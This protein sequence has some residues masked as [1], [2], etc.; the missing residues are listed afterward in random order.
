LA[1]HGPDGTVV[2]D[3]GPEIERNGRTI[4]ARLDRSTTLPEAIWVG[5]FDAHG[6]RSEGET[7]DDV[8]ALA[9]ENAD[10]ANR[11]LEAGPLA[12]RAVFINDATI[13]VQHEVGDLDGLLEYAMEAECVMF[14]AFEGGDFGTAD[15]V[16]QRERV[17]LE[18]LRSCADRV[19]EIE[20]DGGAH[21][22]P[23]GI[24]RSPTSTVSGFDPPD[25]SSRYLRG[26][27]RL[28]GTVPRDTANFGG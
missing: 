17:V 4:G 5:R 9:R 1:H 12:P 18:R 27:L 2:F 14:N 15:P 6:P 24:R 22:H 13:A 3:F 25:D 8:L 23:P 20:E 19:V 26:Q 10:R 28:F 11:L 21:S 7:P 16:S